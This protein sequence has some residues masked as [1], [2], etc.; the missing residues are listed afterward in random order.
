MLLRM[1][2]RWL[3]R[4]GFEF[5]VE[6]METTEQ[7]LVRRATLSI[8]AGAGEAWVLLRGEEGVHRLTRVSPYDSAHRRQTSFATVEVT[9]MRKEK[10]FCLDMGEVRIDTFRSSGNGGQ[11]VNKRDT[12]VRAT[13][14]PTGLTAV[15]QTRHQ[16]R[17]RTLA[18]AALA[19]RVEGASRE[20][21]CRGVPKGRGT[22]AW[23]RQ[24][25]SY[26]F[27]PHAMVKDHRTG[28]R[29]GALQGV[30]DGD[31]DALIAAGAASED[32]RGTT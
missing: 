8:E 3:R 29:S 16:G 14:L 11:N 2:T 10:A 9:P 32:G 31:L 30:L 17:N 23:G 7:G 15:R 6:E 1:Y 28:F 13:H 27:V 18:L 5:E 22:A 12:A 26:A 20:G 24:I 25:R 4:R 21:G 19:A